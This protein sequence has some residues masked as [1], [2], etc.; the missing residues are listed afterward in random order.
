M[1]KNAIKRY[2]TKKGYTIIKT[3]PEEVEKMIPP[4]LP[5]RFFQNSRVC[6]SREE[7]LQY[8]PKGGVIAEV[9]VG[10][11]FFTA[12]LFRYLQPEKLMAI[13]NFGITAGNEPWK[14]TFLEDKNVTHLQFYR[15]KFQKEIETGVMEIHHG[16]SW[17][18]LGQLP[19][20][21]LDYIYLDAGHSYEE[22][23]KDLQQIKRKIKDNGIIQFNDYTLFDSFSFVPY[24]VPRAV[25]EFMIAEDYEML[26]LCLHRQFFCD[27]VVRKKKTG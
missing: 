21:S 19:D 5:A 17:E 8:L 13:D 1:I 14:Q 22:V 6:A 26:F 10:Y 24:G 15:E 7:V 9:G 11:G 12:L 18:M 16:L 27:V 2:L 3:T 25:H 4:E 20:K 23:V